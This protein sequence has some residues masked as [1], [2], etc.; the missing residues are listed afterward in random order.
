MKHN[1]AVATVAPSTRAKYITGDGRA[2]KDVVLAF[3]IEQYVRESGPRI[4]N[5]D[6]ADATG[7]AA[8]GARH[9]GEPLEVRS[10]S[11]DQLAAM[12]GAKWPT[13]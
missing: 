4:V 11:D 12:D 5:D 3:A 13:T 10:I 6:V 8:M 9:L 2:K 7:L 1:I